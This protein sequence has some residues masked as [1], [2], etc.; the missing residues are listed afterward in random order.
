MVQLERETIPKLTGVVQG[1]K[2]YVDD[3]LAYVKDGQVDQ[4][5]DQLNI[6]DP[7]I[8]IDQWYDNI[9]QYEYQLE[10]QLLWNFR[11]L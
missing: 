11:V 2:R 5:L 3:T 4:A 8:Q 7:K 6:Y 1:W 10:T 9:P